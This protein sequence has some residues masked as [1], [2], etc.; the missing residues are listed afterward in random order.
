MD[1]ETKHLSDIFTSFDLHQHVRDLTHTH[2]YTVGLVITR[3]EDNEDM[4]KLTCCTTSDQIADHLSVHTYFKTYK[5]PLVDEGIKY[6]KENQSTFKS[7][8]RT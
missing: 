5:Q 6:R 1:P 8:S 2:G 4:N 7:F 3:D